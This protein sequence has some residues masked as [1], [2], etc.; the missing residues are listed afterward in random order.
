MLGPYF[1]PVAEGPLVAWAVRPA[2]PD[3]SAHLIRHR[4][5]VPLA[6]VVGIKPENFGGP[7]QT[8]PVRER[9]PCAVNAINVRDGYGPNLRRANGPP[10]VPDCVNI[11]AG[12]DGDD[13]GEEKS[14]GSVHKSLTFAKNVPSSRL[15]AKTMIHASGPSTRYQRVPEYQ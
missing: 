15:P 2:I 12:L 5:A 3:A 11:P 8:L 4:I 9:V 14:K 10:T 6:V 7:V 1:A 13:C